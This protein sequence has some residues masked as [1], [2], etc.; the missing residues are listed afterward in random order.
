MHKIVKDTLKAVQKGVKLEQPR[1]NVQKQIGTFD[2]VSA[3]DTL[4]DLFRFKLNRRTQQLMEKTKSLKE[5]KIS[6]Y[7]ISM[8]HTSDLIQDM[9]LAYAENRALGAC[10]D[11]LGQ[12]SGSTK[13]L[14]E[15]VFRVF[16]IDC[17]KRDMGFYATEGAISTKGAAN[18]LIAQNSLIKDLSA[19]IEDLVV[20]LNVPE[21]VIHTPIAADYVT[22]YSKPN[23]GEVVGA[24][25]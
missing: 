20:L 5:D 7:D 3:L 14:M 23:F 10:A 24:K 22:Y 4:V 21:D 9:S 13:P 6:A 25:L 16:A 8:Y 2:D 15:K 19:G 12:I 11:F 17:V 1:M 18:L